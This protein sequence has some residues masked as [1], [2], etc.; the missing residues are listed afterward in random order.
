MDN[1]PKGVPIRYPISI[2]VYDLNNTE[3]IK[4][5]LTEYA[6]KNNITQF[7]SRYIVKATS[8]LTSTNQF[9]T[10]NIGF[11]LP[12]PSYYETPKIKPKLNADDTYL[13][14]IKNY[15]GPNFTFQQLWDFLNQD[16]A[17]DQDNADYY[18]VDDNDHIDG[19]SSKRRR[20]KRRKSKTKKRRKS[21]TKKRRKSKTKKRR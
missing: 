14:V 2:K 1:I 3:E 8:H 19:G 7:D 15:K 12:L 5:A 4:K 13:S 11:F 21:K 16:D 6:L 10:S 17:D 9:D 20:I 18:N